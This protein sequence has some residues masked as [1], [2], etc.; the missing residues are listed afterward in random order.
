MQPYFMPY[1]GYFQLINSVDTFVIYDNLKYTKKGWINRNRILD[2]NGRIQNLT[3]PIEKDSDH[4]D[5]NQ[6]YVSKSFDRK[7][8]VNKVKSYYRKSINYK[9]IAELMDDV[10]IHNQHSC[11]FNYIESS[12]KAVLNVLDIKTE[13]I[14][15]SEISIDHNL[16]GK[17][18]VIAICNKLGADIY[19][20]PIGGVDLYDKS[21]FQNYD[22]ELK[23][24]KSNLSK[25]LQPTSPNLFHPSLSIID[26]IANMNQDDLFKAIANDIEFL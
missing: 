6:R 20:N 4:L 1:I 22:I 3:I 24:L 13:L 18:K 14:R 2:S 5:I 15:S 10:I 26:V 7:K 8:I 16:K 19:I 25:Y 21:F 12:L 11:L 9:I 23:F 17:E